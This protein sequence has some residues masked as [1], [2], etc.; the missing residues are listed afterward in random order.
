[1]GSWGYAMRALGT[2]RT[3]IGPRYQTVDLPT[4]GAHVLRAPTYA[5]AALVRR[6]SPTVQSVGEPG[7]QYWLESNAPLFGAII[8]LCWWHSLY[9]FDADLPSFTAPDAEWLAYGDRVCDELVEHGYGL[10]D[11][12]A[13]YATAMEAINRVHAIIGE[14]QVKADFTDAA[15]G[16]QTSPLGTQGTP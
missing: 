12:G 14:A 7:S 4:H 15:P 3:A 6:L 2:P 5:G 10:E 9:A 16:P 8:G 1:M 11:L 13:L